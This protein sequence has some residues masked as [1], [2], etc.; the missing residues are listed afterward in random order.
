MVPSVGTLSKEKQRRSKAVS[1]DYQ[2]V[3][4]YF[5]LIAIYFGKTIS[6]GGEHSSSIR[7]VD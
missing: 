2:V 3:M 7:Y 1:F 6:A 5:Q 4:A